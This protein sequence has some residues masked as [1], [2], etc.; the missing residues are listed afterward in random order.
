M[1]SLRNKVDCTDQI[2]KKQYII[3]IKQDLPTTVKET[4]E[5]LKAAQ[6]QVQK[7]WKEYQSKR[8]TSLEDQEEA[9]IASQPNMSPLRAARIFKKFKD[10]SGIYSELPTKRHKDGGLS[11]IE[12]PLPMEG[13]ILEYQ[14][15]TDPPLIET[16]ILQWNICHFR[17]A[18]NT[19]L[20]GQEVIDSIKFGTITKTA[21]KI[22]KGTADID[23]IT[24]DPTSKNLFEI[25]KTSKPELEIEVTKEKMMSRYKKWNEHTT[26]SPSGRHLGHYHALCRPFKYDFDNAGDKAEL[27]EKRELI[28]DVHFV[29]LQIAAVNSHVYAR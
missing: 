7:M 21:D 20:A 9:Y 17:Q 29:M 4:T 1:S 13:E 12:V 24:N 2:E 15:L 6:K 16:E 11:T 3:K 8:T 10:S 23:A 28:I 26:T 14:T 5:L 18:D 19:P 25:S 22:L 27:E